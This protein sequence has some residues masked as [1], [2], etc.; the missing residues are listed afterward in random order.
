M[1]RR[2]AWPATKPCVLIFMQ[3]HA[4]DKSPWPLSFAALTLIKKTARSLPELHG[5]RGTCIENHFY[6]CFTY[7]RDT[8]AHRTVGVVFR[9]S[10]A[11][12]IFLEFRHD[13]PD[14]MRWLIF[15]GSQPTE[16]PA[17]ALLANSTLNLHSSIIKRATT[18]ETR[19]LS[20]SRKERRILR[21]RT[22][23]RFPVH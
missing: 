22:V 17:L 20:S 18:F 13:V 2:T 1:C 12:L 3:D 5:L 21:V 19:V 7:I 11:L 16:W 4:G 6:L 14:W 10:R 8:V 9:W 15:N 23:S